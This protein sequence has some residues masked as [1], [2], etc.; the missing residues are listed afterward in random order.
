MDLKADA[1]RTLQDAAEQYPTQ[2]YPECFYA[3]HLGVLSG[4]REISQ[5]VAKAV[6]Y[7]FLWKLG[8]VTS[9]KTHNSSPLDFA[10]PEGRRYWTSR[11]PEVNSRPIALATETDRLQAG[12]SF[13][14][15]ALPYGEFR[16][17]AAELTKQSI[18]LPVFYVHIWRPS[19]YPILDRW[20]WRVFYHERG[21]IVS[22]NAKPRSWPDYEAYRR[23]FVALVETTRLDGRIVDQGLWVLGHRLK[24]S[25]KPTEAQCRG[26]LERTAHA[27]QATPRQS[28]SPPVPA[29]VLD[30]VCRLVAGSATFARFR[31]RG[32][33][34]TRELI[35]A[36]IEE[37]NA[38]PDRLLPQ[39]CR[40]WRKQKTPH[41]L[42]RRIK[43]RLGTDTRTANIVSDVLEAAGVVEVRKTRNQGTGRDVKATKLCPTWSW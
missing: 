24:P 14:E 29:S 4:A 3:H 23:F 38:A 18:V 40:N 11:L 36:T 22:K 28:D 13:R 12:L 19:D 37:L 5:R 20:V 10:D 1:R 32:I 25:L 2:T 17:I 6:E 39:N 42:D 26:P 30:D 8:N 15:G 31:C 43:E 33:W 7:L 27:R 41:G 34:I 35:R 21:D 16:R 9:G